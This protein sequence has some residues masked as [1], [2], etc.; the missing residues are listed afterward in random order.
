MKNWKQSDIG[1][2]NNAGV[3]IK[4]PSP[5]SAQSF[6][7]LPPVKQRKKKSAAEYRLQVSC[8]ALF[9]LLYPELKHL[10]YHVP[11]QAVINNAKI[12]AMLKKLG[13]RRGVWDN[14]LDVARNGWQGMWIEFKSDDGAL[15][16]EQKTF[17]AALEDRYLFLVINQKS[18]F[19][20]QMQEYLGKST[21]SNHQFTKL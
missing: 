5:Q 7:G 18:D 9:D 13:R 1:R 8:V 11:N 4:N 17:R 3:K 2:L 19:G 15:S 10:F 12:G 6:A 14:K 21:R 16:D 20:L